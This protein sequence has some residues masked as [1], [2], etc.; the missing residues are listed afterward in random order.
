[1]VLLAAVLLPVT[2]ADVQRMLRGDALK[3]GLG[4]VLIAVGLAAAALYARVRSDRESILPWFA[5]FALLYGARLLARTETFPLFSSLPAVFWGYLASTIT[6]LIP[7]PAVLLLRT[8]FSSWRRR[9]GWFAVLIAAFAACAIASDAILRRPDSAR[10]PNN[11]IA[12]A[13]MTVS[14]VLLFRPGLR[15]SGDLRALRVGPVAAAITA[16]VD[17]LR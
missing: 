16:V 1:M 9:L 6:Y 17:N 4:V 14:L 10:V 5:L 3:L 13:F 12:I 11:V 2:R 15:T 8:V 7:I